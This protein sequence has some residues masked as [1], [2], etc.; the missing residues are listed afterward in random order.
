M[1]P[2]KKPELLQ[3]F[4]SRLDQI[5]NNKHPLF[6]AAKQIDWGALDARFGAFYTEERGAPAKPTRLLV[7][8]HYLKHVFDESDESVVA[9]FI[10]N[11]YWQYLYGFE[12]FQHFFPIDPSSM[13]YW[14]QRIGESG[15]ENLLDELLRTAERSGTLN[16]T[17]LKRVCVDTTVQEKGISFPTD[18]RLYDKM[19]KKLVKAARKSGIWLRQSY[20][21][22]AKKALIKQSRYAHAK[23]YKRARRMTRKLKTWLGRV[24]RDIER[25]AHYM[26]DELVHVLEL[27]TRLLAQKR[28]DSNKL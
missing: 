21:L 13:T 20:L 19:R 14:R 4:Q 2:K 11:P 26:D 17:D 25:K 10:E 16:R 9:R 24:H 1:K 15:A 8:L 7:G 23:Q 27:S 22:V 5:L 28:E 3:L 12:Y 6:V 18:A